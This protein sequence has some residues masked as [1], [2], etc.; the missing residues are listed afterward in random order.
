MLVQILVLVLKMSLLVLVLDSIIQRVDVTSSS[1]NMLVNVI[2]LE[3][4]MSRSV[5]EQVAV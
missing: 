2:L 3:V 1:A 4:I 5:I